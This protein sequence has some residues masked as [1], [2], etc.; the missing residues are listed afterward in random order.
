MSC[1]IIIKEEKEMTQNSE[2]YC[3]RQ[4]AGNTDG[5]LGEQRYVRKSEWLAGFWISAERRTEKTVC[6]KV[7]VSGEVNCERVDILRF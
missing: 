7:V 2:V 6:C 1:K 5:G 3:L 4:L